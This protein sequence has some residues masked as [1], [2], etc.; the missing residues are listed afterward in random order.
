MPGQSQD[1][2]IH[3]RCGHAEASLQCPSHAPII[4]HGC[5]YAFESQCALDFSEKSLRSQTISVDI[6]LRR[7][8]RHRRRAITCMIPLAT[9]Y[10]LH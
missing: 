6:A 2:T 5:Q 4:V 1:L 9:S 7:M 8:A 3:K 10:S